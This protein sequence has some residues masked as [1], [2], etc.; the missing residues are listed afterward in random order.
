MFI[1]IQWSHFA[2][3]GQRTASSESASHTALGYL[4]EAVVRYLHP[5]LITTAACESN[6]ALTHRRAESLLR[7][8]ALKILF[9][10]PNRKLFAIFV[11]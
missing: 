8:F 11:R 9:K 10:Q 5:R 3:T 2:R 1:Q 4:S 7:L 6:A